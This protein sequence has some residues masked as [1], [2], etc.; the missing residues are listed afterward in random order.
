M[1][2]ISQEQDSL[3]K[4][5]K[6][7]SNQNR[8]NIQ[9]EENNLHNSQD[10]TDQVVK[11]K[12]KKDKEK[13]KKMDIPTYI[14]KY[15][16]YKRKIYK[17]KQLFKEIKKE[18]DEDKNKLPSQ[19][20]REDKSGC[21]CGCVILF[22][23]F[24]MVIGTDFIAPIS[25]YKEENYYE[26]SDDSNVDGSILELLIFV[27]ISI[28]LSFIFSAYTVVIIFSTTRRRYISGDFL[29]DK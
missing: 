6:P 4:Y 15:K 9:S 23:V 2:V 14:R 25:L 11:N 5:L 22:I 13:N 18:K 29:Y 3:V 10:N 7:N 20:S 17:L 19:D 8:R 21:S 12:D 26:S 24:F 28:A 27:L 16:N 1:Q